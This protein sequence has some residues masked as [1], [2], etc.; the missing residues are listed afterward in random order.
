MIGGAFVAGVGGA[1]HG[2]PQPGDDEQHPPVVGLGEDHR[3]ILQ[4][5][6]GRLHDEVNPLAVDDGQG[7]AVA[8]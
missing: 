5:Q 7:G 2:G 3:P 4:P 8:L 6:G 1:D